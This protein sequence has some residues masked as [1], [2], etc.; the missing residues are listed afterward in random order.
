MAVTFRIRGRAFFLLLAC[1]SA[2]AALGQEAP[3]ASL[4]VMWQAPEAL[5]ELLEKY[6]PPPRTESGAR[7]AASLRPWMREVRRRV[8]QIAA[9]EGYFSATVEIEFEAESREHATITVTPGPRATVGEVQMSFAGDLAGQ[10]EERET[11]RRLLRDAWMMKPGAPFRSGD[12]ETA[13]SRLEELLVQ[14]DYAAGKLGESEAQVDVEA[15]KATL[16]LVLDSGPRFTLGEVRIEG[17]A[18]YPEAVIRRSISLGPGERYSAAK[19]IDVQRAIQSGP[20]F[21]SV[22]VDVERDAQHPDNVPV[23]IV[24]TERPTREAG[25]AL[26]FGTD[27]GA[28]AEAAFRH[29]DILDRGLD[30]QSSIRAAQNRQIGYA[31]IYLPSGIFAT[32]RLGEISFQDSV[33]VLAEHSTIQKLAFSRFAVAGYRHFKLENWELRAGLTYQVER[34][35]PEG[36]EP[37]ITR[38]LAPVVAVTAR[39]VDDLFD[40]KKGGVLNVQFAAATKDLAS[41]QDFFKAYA[42]LQYWI[43]VTSKDQILLRTEIGSTFAQSREGIP[44]DFL[45]RAGGSRSNRGYAYQSLGP[46][47]GDAIVGG[48]YIA[49]GSAEYV[50]WLDE[51]WGAALF[52]DVGDAADTPKDWRVNTSYG[53]GARFKTPA[54]P[55]ALDLA[56]AERERR[57]RLSF[58]VTVAF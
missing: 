51:R 43:P 54:G 20:W 30:L 14:E 17:L 50:H 22:L 33:G 18:K 15:S 38:A 41:S 37:N 25:L 35:F 47:E 28:R 3:R 10:G 52:A 53:V 36:A 29:R 32:P 34:K 26:G 8:P 6:L 27:D 5:K 48:R 11:R 16:K 39:H 31:D 57:F 9:S 46:R 45:F 1:A 21:S 58:S 12:W 40:P 44:E 7:R 4:A 13:K 19:L 2:T 23:K 24:V 42:H 55:F 56:Y 49:T